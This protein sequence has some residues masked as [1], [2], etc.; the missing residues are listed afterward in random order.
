MN[1][2]E[3][4]TFYDSEEKRSV[5]FDATFTTIVDEGQIGS[6]YNVDGATKLFHETTTTTWI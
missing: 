2:L 6:S 5:A 4:D 3:V 1:Q